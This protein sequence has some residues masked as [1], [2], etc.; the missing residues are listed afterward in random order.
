MSKKNKVKPK[1]ENSNFLAVSLIAVSALILA[2][3]MTDGDG[4]TSLINSNLSSSSENKFNSLKTNSNKVQSMDVN[5]RAEQKK[6][7]VNKHL[8]YTN[9][10]IIAH[11]KELQ[12][13]AYKAPSVGM[14]ISPNLKEQNNT[15]D[16]R[17]DLNEYSAVQDTAP[18]KEL[19][20]YSPHAVIQGQI[21]DQ[22]MAAAQQKAESEAFIKQFL[23]NA[24]Q[25]GYIVILDQN[26]VVVEVKTVPNY[27]KDL[28][29]SSG[30]RFPTTQDQFNDSVNGSSAG[31]R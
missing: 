17:S 31:T 29:N 23:E 14:V 5:A 10:K 19:N 11:Q 20:Y 18:R 27:R 15:L 12:F 2:M 30:S 24:R 26:N 16:M 1:N 7:I 6:Q 8:Y 4:V 21:R 13:Q 22:E 9:E 25:N 28:H 3:S